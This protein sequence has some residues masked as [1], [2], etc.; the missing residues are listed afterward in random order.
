MRLTSLESTSS[1]GEISSTSSNLQDSSSEHQHQSI[2]SMGKLSIPSITSSITSSPTKN[3]PKTPQLQS[4][5]LYESYFDDSYIG[6]FTGEVPPDAQLD[7]EEAEHQDWPNVTEINSTSGV[8]EFAYDSFGPE[9]IVFANGSEESTFPEETLNGKVTAEEN[10]EKRGEKNEEEKKNVEQIPPQS[11]EDQS[12]ENSPRKLDEKNVLPTPSIFQRTKLTASQRKKLS[13]QI[14]FSD[15]MN[16][17]DDVTPS[18][19]EYHPQED[20]VGEQLKESIPGE[21]KLEETEPSH[22]PL[23]FE[24]S[25]IEG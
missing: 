19:I 12:E 13:P 14:N 21:E 3:S 8:V 24:N 9:S 11:D 10:E 6:D 16:T 15:I 17:S 2:K 18:H 20:E 4:I 22:G 25:T 23:Q 5:N 1:K 7:P